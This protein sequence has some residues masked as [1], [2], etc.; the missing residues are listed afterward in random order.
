MTTLPSA[1]YPESILGLWMKNELLL[2]SSSAANYQPW[3]RLVE[4]SVDPFFTLATLMPGSLR[5]VAY[6]GDINL[7]GRMTLSPSATGTLELLAGGAINGLRPTGASSSSVYGSGQ[8]TIWSSA[9]LNVSDADPT[10]IPGVLSPF[11]YYKTYYNPAVSNNNT[12][13]RTTSSNFLSV[14]DAIFA[15]S[16]STTGTYASSQVKQQLHAAGLL[17]L[18]DASPVRIYA[19]GGDLSGLTLFSPKAASILASRDITDI[20]FYIQNLRSSD[21]S[22]VS[23]GRDIIAYNANSILRSQA[24]STGNFTALGSITEL[25]KS[26]DIQINGPGSLQVLAGP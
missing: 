25:P 8:T 9:T 2:T 16:G 19:T 18:N 6:S 14:Y 10:S 23:S 13:A 24:V 1:T 20:A 5:A 11:A 7:V 12:A 22:I 26:G 17:H 15:E 21:V 4:T 3:L